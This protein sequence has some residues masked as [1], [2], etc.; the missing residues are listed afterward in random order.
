MSDKKPY[1]VGQLVCGPGEADRYLEETLN[2]FQR[3]CDAAVIC[4]CGN[5]SFEKEKALLE[6]Y[7][8]TFIYYRDERE[9]GKHQPDVKTTLLET[10]LRE[11][12]ADWIVAL[13][14]DETLPTVDRAEL[15]RIASGPRESAYFYV[16][17]LWNSPE[18][19]MRSLAFWNIRFY[20][21]DASKGTQFLRKPVHC[22]NAPPYF[23]NQKAK[24]SYVPHIMLHKGLMNPKDR[25][26]K[27]G[28]YRNYD[29]N[30]LHKGQEYYDALAMDANGSEYDQAAVVAKITDYCNQIGAL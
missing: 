9:W 28:R 6:K 13:D 10:I 19:Y 5:D 22:G 20:K 29:P 26:R 3:L 16:V 25:A 14:A 24:V 7:G 4:L 17:N 2:E 11:T 8:S 27:V 1:I 30:A 12:Q 18:R 23:Y 15:E 21:A